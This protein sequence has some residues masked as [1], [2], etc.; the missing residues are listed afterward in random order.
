MD[1][2][3]VR[4]IWT[5]VLP[6]TSSAK[7]FAKWLCRLVSTFGILCGWKRWWGRS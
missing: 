7:A 2:C 3:E 5:M 1:N 4:R 6:R